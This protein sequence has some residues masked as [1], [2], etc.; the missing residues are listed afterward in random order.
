MFRG[1]L[2]GAREAHLPVS[3]F[4]EITYLLAAVSEAVRQQSSFFDLMP[5]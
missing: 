4:L 1:L 5:L 2:T 3:L